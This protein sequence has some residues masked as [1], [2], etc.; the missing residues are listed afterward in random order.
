MSVS[1]H[2]GLTALV[3]AAMLA[4]LSCGGVADRADSERPVG[5][6]DEPIVFNDNGAWSWFE[7]ERAVVDA[8][9][10][11]LLISS[12]ASAGGTGGASREGNVEVVAH[13]LATG[14]N[15]R[16]VLHAHLQADD[17]DSAALYVRPDGRYLAMYS[18]HAS[19][20][21]SRWRISRRPGD[22]TDW[23]A[24]ATFDHGAP[25]TYSNL[26]AADGDRL[27]AFVRTT[28]RD[29]HLLVS[30]DHGTTWRAGGRLIDGPG[31][32]YVRYAADPSGRIQLITTEQHPLDFANRIYHGAVVAGHL[33][34]SDGSVVDG[35]LFDAVAVAPEQLTTVF[36]GTK[37]DH[38]WPIDL[39]V[40]AAGHPFAVFS[41]YTQPA[42]PSTPS[43]AGRQRYYYARYDGRTWRVHHMAEAGTPLYADELFYTGLAALHP[44]DPDRVFVS[45]DVDPA[46][47]VPVVSAADGQ[48]HHELFEGVTSDGGATWTWMAVTADSTVD[49]LRPI[50]PIWDAER[51]AL[52]W[53]RGT[54]TTYKDYNLDVVGIIS[55]GSRSVVDARTVPT[56]DERCGLTAP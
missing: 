35:N 40:D 6:P 16:S 28:G 54:Y 45:T 33:R 51:T 30:D 37:A 52:L 56:S 44:N 26:Y 53:L 12:L 50:V 25:T 39:Q 2:R 27:F 1:H 15:R 21:L 42:S 9:A 36:A 4:S 49:N 22:A 47:G 19:D 18:Q 17:H 55:T 11:T 14:H 34:R 41:V 46:T 10:G 24:E 20:S 29:P 13:D 38:A 43:P 3:P 31:R 7:D 23:E 8:A 5:C 32:P 48:S